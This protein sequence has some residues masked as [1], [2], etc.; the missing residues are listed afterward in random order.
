MAVF[1]KEE[2]LADLVDVCERSSNSYR[3]AM[4]AIDEQRELF[5]DTHA[6]STTRR[7]LGMRRNGMQNHIG[8]IPAEVWN[9]DM[10]LRPNI[11]IRERALDIL[12]RF[13]QFRTEVR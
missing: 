6:P 10:I 13:P 4:Q 3:E 12:K 8:A 7:P 9:A 2:I 1:S 5:E 11:S